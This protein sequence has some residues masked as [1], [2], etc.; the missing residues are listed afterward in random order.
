MTA[1]EPFGALNCE[2][3]SGRPGEMLQHS[4]FGDV[5]PIVLGAVSVMFSIIAAIFGQCGLQGCPGADPLAQ[6]S[7]IAT[8]GEASRLSNS[9]KA[10]SLMQ[11]FTINT[12]VILLD[13]YASRM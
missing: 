7:A 4:D 11:I 5:A 8:A 3:G 9:E 6:Q 1:E 10:T 12:S 2:T 13:V